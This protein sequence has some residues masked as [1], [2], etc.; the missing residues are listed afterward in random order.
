M[1]ST[2]LLDSKLLDLVHLIQNL[3][4][5]KG[6][7]TKLNSRTQKKKKKKKPPPTHTHTHQMPYTFKYLKFDLLHL[8]EF[9][10]HSNKISFTSNVLYTVKK[11]QYLSLISHVLLE[12]KQLQRYQI[13]P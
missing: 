11:S 3:P 10:T 13:N 8:R 12:S 9:L 6:C 7:L 1:L 2:G 4:L 5:F